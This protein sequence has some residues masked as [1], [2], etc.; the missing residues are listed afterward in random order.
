[1]KQTI[2]S[3]NQKN[4]KKKDD[5][6]DELAEHAPWLRDFADK[7]DSLRVPPDYFAS[8]EDSVF[9]QL[10]AIGAM[11]QPPAPKPRPSLW[12]ML[13]AL[14]QPRLALAIAG[15][16]AVLLAAWWLFRPVETVRRIEQEH[17]IVTAEDVETYLLENPMVLELD[18][19]VAAL[20]NDQLPVVLLDPLPSDVSELPIHLSPEDLENLLRDI[21]SEELN[22]LI[23]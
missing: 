20:P 5:L 16:L 13:Q 14:W 18:Q 3:E 2:R 10:T 19:L 4:M 22:N 6:H 15:T 8:V 9:Q 1:V 7:K 23:L 11:R 17:P 12:Q 21:T